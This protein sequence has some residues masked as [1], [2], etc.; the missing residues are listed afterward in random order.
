[1]MCGNRKVTICVSGNAANIRQN[2]VVTFS[3]YH[4]GGRPGIYRLV[5]VLGK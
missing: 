5:K 1:M 4:V 3:K 2:T